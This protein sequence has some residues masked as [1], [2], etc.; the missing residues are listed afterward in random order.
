MWYYW[1]TCKL[2]RALL[3]VLSIESEIP[4][5]CAMLFAET[6]AGKQKVEWNGYGN[7]PFDEAM[8]CV[9]CRPNYSTSEVGVPAVSEF[10][11]ICAIAA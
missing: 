11:E 1:Y 7:R 5:L 10:T 8:P 9:L 4:F 6:A 3:R 2:N